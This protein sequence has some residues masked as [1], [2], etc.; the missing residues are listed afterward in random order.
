MTIEQEFESQG[1]IKHSFLH[2]LNPQ[3]FIWHAVSGREG[4][5][6]TSMKTANSGYI[7]R[8]MIKLMEDVQVKYDGTV[9]NTNNWVVQWAYGSDGFDRSEC[10]FNHDGNVN[11]VDVSRIADRLN[12]EYEL[13]I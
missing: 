8:K 10:S 3:E 1:F 9:R 5:S 6:D 4:C 2:G 7:Q 13:Q 11:F 12:N